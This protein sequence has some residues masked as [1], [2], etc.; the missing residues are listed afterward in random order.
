VNVVCWFAF[1]MPAR[2]REKEE[3]S[4]L[5]HDRMRWRAEG[6]RLAGDAPET[7]VATRRGAYRRGGMVANDP[8]RSATRG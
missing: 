8:S 1:S 6:G 7:R 2:S 5:C 3:K 4:A